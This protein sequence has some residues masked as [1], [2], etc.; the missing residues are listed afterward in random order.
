M[1]LCRTGHLY[2]L[3]WPLIQFQLVQFYFFMYR[4]NSIF[5]LDDLDFLPSGFIFTMYMK[6]HK[7]DQKQREERKRQ[8]L[9]LRPIRG[10]NTKMLKRKTRHTTLLCLAQSV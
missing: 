7:P 6:Q 10:E 4:Q 3:T 2:I 8:N 5:V 9:H 1:V